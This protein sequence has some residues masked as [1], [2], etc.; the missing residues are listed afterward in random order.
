MDALGEAL[1]TLGGCLDTGHYSLSGHGSLLDT[2]YRSSAVTST[3]LTAA[4]TTSTATSGGHHHLLP[5]YSSELHP[6]SVNNDHT[7][8]SGTLQN[9]STAQCTPPVLGPILEICPIQNYDTTRNDHRL[10]ESTDDKKTQAS[11]KP[12]NICIYRDAVD[13]CNTGII[14][15]SQVNYI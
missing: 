13:I 5:L 8:V 10:R 15:P 7:Q 14:S 12:G 1:D 4:S 6:R 9:S 2:G 11:S 3:S